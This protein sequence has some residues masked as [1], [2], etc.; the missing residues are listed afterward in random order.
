MF[1]CNL[2]LQDPEKAAL[3]EDKAALREELRRLEGRFS[4]LQDDYAEAQFYTSFQPMVCFP[5]A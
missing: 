3:R 2:C 1:T 4:R 5:S